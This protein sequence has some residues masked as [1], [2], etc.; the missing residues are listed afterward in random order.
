MVGNT[1]D[2]Q[3]SAKSNIPHMQFQL[4]CAAIEGESKGMKGN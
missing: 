2:N 3:D 4:K 1:Q